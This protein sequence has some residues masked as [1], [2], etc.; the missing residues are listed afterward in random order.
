MTTTNIMPTTFTIAWNVL[1]GDPDAI[2]RF[3]ISIADAS[4]RVLLSQTLPGQTRSFNLRGLQPGAEYRAVLRAFGTS[5]A[6][7]L[8]EA[9]ASA[10]TLTSDGASPAVTSTRGDEFVAGDLTSNGRVF[11]QSEPVCGLAVRR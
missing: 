6:A 10:V 11:I 9:K 7:P 4:D 1:T 2:V 3:Q 8:A 5:S